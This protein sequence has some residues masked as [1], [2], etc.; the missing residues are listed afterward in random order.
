V[1]KDVN[2]AIV[3][4]TLHLF[5]FVPAGDSKLTSIDI[6]INR[7][8]TAAGHWVQTSH[9]NSTTFFPGKV[10][11]RIQYSN[12]GRFCTLIGGVTIVIDGA[13]VG[14]I[15]VSDETPTEDVGICKAGIRVIV[16]L[17]WRKRGLEL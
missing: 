11:F 14:A 7:A 6:A 16:P 5:L 3:D 8:Y 9:Y 1:Q 2:I 12:G 10:G 4:S 13:V 17:I 15:G